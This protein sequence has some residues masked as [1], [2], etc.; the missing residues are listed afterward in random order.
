MART[1][2]DIFHITIQQR[3]TVL[4]AILYSLYS[5]FPE[6]QAAVPCSP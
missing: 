4:S 2:K 3:C 6:S 1:E 5:Y